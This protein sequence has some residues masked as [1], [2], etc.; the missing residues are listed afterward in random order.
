MYVQVFNNMLQLRMVIRVVS[1]TCMY[2]AMLCTHLLWPK[3]GPHIRVHNRK[4]RMCT[5]YVVPSHMQHTTY[6]ENA[7]SPT[8]QVGQFSLEKKQTHTH[9]R[10]RANDAFETVPHK[11]VTH[12]T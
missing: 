8:L 12:K 6:T 3:I 9:T 7:S 5:A 4:I 2:H 10:K 1:L 11:V